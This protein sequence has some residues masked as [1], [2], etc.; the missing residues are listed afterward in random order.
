MIRLWPQKKPPAPVVKTESFRGFQNFRLEVFTE[1]KKRIA[2][3]EKMIILAILGSIQH[4]F[5]MAHL[6]YWNAAQNYRA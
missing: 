2:Q 6:N 5:V 3:M 4:L 1:P